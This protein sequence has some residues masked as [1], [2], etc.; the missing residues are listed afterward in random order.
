MD[1]G[2]LPA[3][4]EGYA[5]LL[6]ELKG[7]IRN[8]RLKASL[9]VNRELV[10]LYWTIGRDILRRQD[11]EG[12]GTKVIDQ[13]SRDLRKSFPD[14]TGFSARNLKYMR[15]LAAAWPDEAVV[16]QAV[17]QL[18]WGHNLR[19]LDKVK[20]P[21]EREWY[22]KACVEHGWSRAV[23][24]AQIDTG[25][26]RRQGQ[27]RTNFDRTLPSAPQSELAQQSLKDPYCFEFLGLSE[28]ITERKLHQ[29]LLANLRDLLLELGRGFAFLGS[30]YRLD[31]GGD[32]F[33]IDLLFYH[34]LLH[35]YVVVELK[36]SAFQPE[37][38]GQ[39]QFYLSAVDR[40]LRGELDGPTVGI[41][42]CTKKNEVVV[43]VALQDSNKP[44]GVAEYR[45]TEA[46]PR[47][48]RDALPSLEELK[49]RVV[50]MSGT[51]E[52]RAEFTGRLTVRGTE[53]AEEG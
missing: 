46:L 1:G 9:A 30:E 53:S 18:P 48:V 37:H 49:A 34:T 12:W 43:E 17:A 23:L 47:R 10:V 35:S 28:E 14:V 22:I 19:L 8:A 24:E 11:Q 29:S 6:E 4:P 26:F 36:T 39:L 52:A 7:R 20:D 33:R 2:D 40:C 32:E 42:L 3:K 38:V 50:S 27:A 21:H 31:V 13:L 5:E 16:Q 15:A 41:L 25:L 44:M 45:L 51:L